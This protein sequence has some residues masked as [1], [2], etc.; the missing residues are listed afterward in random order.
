M[1]DYQLTDTDIVIRTRDFTNVP[2][3]P[4]NADRR[5]YERWLSWGNTPDPYVPMNQPQP[6]AP[7]D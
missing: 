6:K 4:G 2:N 1:A 7:D 3:I 5:E